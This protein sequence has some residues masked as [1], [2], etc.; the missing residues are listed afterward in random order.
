MDSFYEYIQENNDY[1]TTKKIKIN[2]LLLLNNLSKRQKEMVNNNEKSKFLRS[3]K[4]QIFSDNDLIEINNIFSANFISENKIINSTTVLK[5]I[6]DVWGNEISTNNNNLKVLLDNLSDIYFEEYIQFDKTGT[7]SPIDSTDNNYSNFVIKCCYG[8][9]FEESQSD[10]FKINKTSEIIEKTIL[11]KEYEY[12]TENNNIVKIA[13]KDKKRNSQTL[14]DKELNNLINIYKRLKEKYN[15]E[16]SFNFKVS[17]GKIY[18]TD[19]EDIS[20]VIPT[21]FKEKI[22]LNKV[23]NNTL[24]LTYSWKNIFFQ[25]YIKTISDVFY[26]NMEKELFFYN[27][28]VYLENNFLN[29]ITVSSPV[30]LCRP[31]LVSEILNIENKE[32]FNNNIFYLEYIRF[33]CKIFSEKKYKK[34]AEQTEDNIF[35]WFSE[36]ED[37][38]SYSI[39][40]L[41]QFAYRIISY[42]KEHWGII[43]INELYI[44]LLSSKYNTTYHNYKLIDELNRIVSYL[45]KETL[46]KLKSGTEDEIKNYLSLNKTEKLNIDIFIKTFKTKYFISSKLEEQDV[47]IYKIIGKWNILNIENPEIKNKKLLWH[48]SQRENYFVYKNQITFLI[49]TLIEKIASKMV[50]TKEIEKI[51]DIYFLSLDELYQYSYKISTKNILK[52]IVKARRVMPNTPYE[53]VVTNSETYLN[54]IIDKKDVFIEEKDP[55]KSHF[56]NYNDEFAKSILE[57]L[58]KGENI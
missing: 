6:L 2:K 58:E 34:F 7:F 15:T 43:Y 13:L 57:E 41:I 8:N 3:L 17:N 9:C 44:K 42:I 26:L 37:S 31:M 11:E 32:N 5:F 25:T 18:I 28:T 21:E 49:K 39:S 50:L 33:L 4:H 48:I 24:P 19:I 30:Y 56:E 29:P 38:D 36:L 12:N 55:L 16:K 47:D 53:F 23:L 14:S 46:E 40:E 54:Y 35:N 52:N 22:K 51:E 45:S 20:L 27:G 10:L 1:N